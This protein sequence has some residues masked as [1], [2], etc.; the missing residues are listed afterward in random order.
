[1]T[2]TNYQPLLSNKPTRTKT[3]TAP[4]Q[5]PKISHIQMM[6]ANINDF[7]TKVFQVYKHENQF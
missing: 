1:M 3:S 6:F 4:Q 7:K 5:K 2:A